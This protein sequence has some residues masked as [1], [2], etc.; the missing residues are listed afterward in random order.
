MGDGVFDRNF[1]SSVKQYVVN[2]GVEPLTLGETQERI[3]G[4]ILQAMIAN[5]VNVSKGS[6]RADMIRL[7]TAASNGIVLPPPTLLEAYEAGWTGAGGIAVSYDTSSPL[8]ASGLRAKGT[9]ASSGTI[10]TKSPSLLNQSPAGYGTIAYRLRLNKVN[11]SGNGVSIPKLGISASYVD[12]IPAGYSFTQAPA[13]DYW[14]AMNVSEIALL[15]GAAP[16]V[17]VDQQVRNYN[18]APYNSDVTVDSLMVNAPGLATCLIT[19]DDNHD[20][21]LTVA[22]PKLDEYNFKATSFCVTGGAVG[23]GSGTSL[24]YAGFRT[25]QDW[26]WLVGSDSPDDTAY[27]AQASVAAANAFWKT[28]AAT[29]AA[30]GLPRGLEFGCW[31][32]STTQVNATL[33]QVATCTP[34]DNAGNLV[35]SVAPG[36]A[37]QVGDKLEMIGASGDCTVDVVTDTTHVHVVGTTYPA[38]GVGLPATFWTPTAFNPGDL[39]ANFAAD[40]VKMMRN[41]GGETK[42]GE[43]FYSRF[44][45]SYNQFNCPAISVARQTFAQ[46][47]AKIDLEVARGNT[48]ILL[49]HRLDDGSGSGFWTTVAI[50]AQ[51]IDYVNTLKVSGLLPGGVITLEQLYLRDFANPAT[52]PSS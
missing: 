10:A 29:M 8:G 26:G 24:T 39:A 42:V 4:K 3:W 49:F 35:F 15:A 7:L 36:T 40:G 37:V 22:K 28:N 45:G 52:P 50:H 47:K 5:G 31:P 46:I 48:F 32:N 44:G 43:G 27:T 13:G 9:G 33:K 34:S 2:A 14:V 19:Y 30:N 16:G 20:T 38:S 41:G 25:L 23:I 6:S 21:Q 51:I 1:W 18:T 11:R 17:T 12:I